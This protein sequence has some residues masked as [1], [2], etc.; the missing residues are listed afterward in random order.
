LI[1]SIR[2]NHRLAVGQ[3]ANAP[4]GASTAWSFVAIGDPNQNAQIRLAAE[5]RKSGVL[6]TR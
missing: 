6:L 1:P 4:S 3:Q 2:E 5:E